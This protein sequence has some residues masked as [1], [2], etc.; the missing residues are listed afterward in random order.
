[1]GEDQ[2]IDGALGGA[3]CLFGGVPYVSRGEALEGNV[4]HAAGVGKDGGGVG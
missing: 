1:M 4:V 2:G 3:P